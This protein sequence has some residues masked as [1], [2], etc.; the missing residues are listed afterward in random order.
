MDDAL[1]RNHYF[2]ALTTTPDLAWMGQNT[3]HIIPAYPAVKATMIAAIEAGEPGSHPSALVEAAR[4]RGVMIRQG[5]YHKARLGERFVKISTSVPEEWVE[6]F[7]R[8]LPDIVAEART[9]NDLPPPF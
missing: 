8:L 1:T 6:R 4:R 2:D 3:N 9:L 7:C 5:T